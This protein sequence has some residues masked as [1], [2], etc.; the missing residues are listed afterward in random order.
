[1]PPLESEDAAATPLRVHLTG[2]GPFRHH[3]VNASWEAVRPLDGTAL[4]ALTPAD[5]AKPPG[6]PTA[7]PVEL[8]CSL[9]P[10]KYA[11]ALSLVPALHARPQYDLVIHCGVSG[12]NRIHLERRARKFG[13]EQL[14]VD[15]QLAPAASDTR[16]G[17]PQPEWESCPEELVTNIDTAR[18]CRVAQRR[19]IEHVAPSDDAGLYLCEFTYYTSLAS[20]RTQ[21]PQSPTPVLFVHVP[22]ADQPYSIEQLTAALRVII[23]AATHPGDPGEEE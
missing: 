9:I 18:L 14:D 21:E 8:S 15:G 12:G 19:G 4:T 22:P 7:R 6:L 10:V 17:F 5:G 1:M 2:F 20:A 16:R 11:S 13:Y 23:W 3:A